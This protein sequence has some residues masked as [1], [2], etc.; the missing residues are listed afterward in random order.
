MC[1]CGRGS[2]AMLCIECE[3][4]SGVTKVGPPHCEPT[5]NHQLV[6]NPEL[7]I[8][9]VRPASARVS[10]IAILRAVTVLHVLPERLDTSGGWVS[11]VLS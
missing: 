1:R 4:I 6:R 7:G 8:A 3:V 2:S 9:W 10:R 5:F 11:V